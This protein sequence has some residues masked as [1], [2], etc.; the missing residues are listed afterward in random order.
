MTAGAIESPPAVD[1]EVDA[2]LQFSCLF[3]TFAGKRHL[4]LHSDLTGTSMAVFSP[5][6][7]YRYLLIRRWGFGPLIC[8]LMLNPSTADAM[9]SDPT[10]SRCQDF[11]VRWGGSGFLVANLY[12][13]RS[14][15]P[16]A[17]YRATD[18]VGGEHNKA[19]IDLCA[20]SSKFTV[21]A[22]GNHGTHNNR[23]QV[24]TRWL[25]SRGTDLRALGVNRTGE[26]VHPLYQPKTA[27]PKLYLGHA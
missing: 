23:G 6:G 3:G 21:C 12:A 17:L 8:F 2:A 10:V 9:V 11:T 7:L 15:D 27:E 25:R 5:C 26:P 16:K 19:A 20:S 24:V 13:L 14:T 4:T 22:W 1:A 18:S